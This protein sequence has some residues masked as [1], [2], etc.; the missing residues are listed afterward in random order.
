[1]HA[2]IASLVTIMLSMEP[3]IPLSA[4]E[5]AES[6]AA[7]AERY[8]SIAEDVAHVAYD[9][10]ERPLYGGDRGRLQ[11]ALL[12][13]ATAYDETRW[14]LDAETIEG[15]QRL[16]KRGLLDGGTSWCIMQIHVGR[17]GRT[18]EGWSGHDLL[19]DRSR[20]IR[21]GYR[22]IQRSMGACWALALGDRLSAYVAGKCSAGHARSRSRIRMAGWW[23]RKAPAETDMEAMAGNWDGG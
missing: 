5:R 7:R 4:E 8:E 20:C 2:I 19:E 6:P 22:L 12:V 14:R 15:H 21:A 16:A 17:T 1:M 9:F 3:A 13:L 10:D 11:S 23:A 18:A